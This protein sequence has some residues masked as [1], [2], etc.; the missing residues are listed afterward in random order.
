MSE[1]S[2]LHKR[3]EKEKKNYNKKSAP[4]INYNLKSLFCHL[5]QRPLN[6]GHFNM[7]NFY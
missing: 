3:E 1:I 2:I 5:P 6:L 4:I 7:L